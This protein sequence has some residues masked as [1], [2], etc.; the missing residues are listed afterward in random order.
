LWDSEGRKADFHVQT[1]LTI[2]ISIGHLV[3]TRAASKLFTTFYVQTFYPFFLKTYSIYL[4]SGWTPAHQIHVWRSNR[5]TIRSRL[6]GIWGRKTE[7]APVVWGYFLKI[8]LIR[9]VRY[10]AN[11]CV[12]CSFPILFIRDPFICPFMRSLSLHNGNKYTTAYFSILLH[13]YLFLASFLRLANSLNH[14][15]FLQLQYIR[16]LQLLVNCFFCPYFPPILSHSPY[17]SYARCIQKHSKL[18][19]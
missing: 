17:F 9:Y 1:P 18:S 8:C 15:T 3:G 7:R 10:M 12:F 14:H 5:Q 19:R 16:L 13:L 2:L 6:Q 4:R 11:R